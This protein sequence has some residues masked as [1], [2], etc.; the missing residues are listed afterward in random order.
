[1]ERTR[2]AG[3]TSSDLGVSVQILRDTS[4]VP[5]NENCI[6]ALKPEDWTMERRINTIFTTTT[7]EVVH[8]YQYDILGGP[9]G[10][11]WWT[12]GIPEWFSYAPGMYDQRL[13][14]LAT[15]Q[16]IPSLESGGIGSDLTQADGCYA[17][18][19]DVGP[20]FINY[21][22]TNYGGPETHRQIAELMRANSS[23][24]E[25]VETVTGKP[26]LEIENEWR[27]YLGFPVLDLADIDPSA[28]LEPAIDP[29]A[30]VG[31]TVTLPAVP[32][33]PVVHANAG[34]NQPTSGQCFANTAVEI[35]QI[36]SLDG[37]DYYQVDCMGQIGWMDRG[38]LVGPGN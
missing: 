36:G 1:V 30:E 19:Y 7:H 14:N 9:L 24:F 17:L 32:V 3:Y 35:L 25:A 4:L 28:A 18:S 6:W 23:I 2:V 10:D 15:L 8:L 22:L 20:S 12:E 11:E 29:V 27:T 13:R 31:D 33:M 34:P 26:F 37:V 38:E 5:G 16:D 21:L